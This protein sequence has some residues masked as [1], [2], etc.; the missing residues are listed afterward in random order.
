MV[1]KTG[2]RALVLLAPLVLVAALPVAGQESPLQWPVPPPGPPRQTAPSRLLIAA[3]DAAGELAA[4]AVPLDARGLG[5]AFAAGHLP[6]A[7][8]AWSAGDE[9][10]DLARVRSRLAGAGI[11]GAEAVVLYGE[12]SGSGDGGR[13]AVARL[14]WLLRWA[15]VRDVRLLAGGLV[16]WRAGGGA[17]ETG[18]PR[19]APAAAFHPAA[20]PGAAA[21]A[22]WISGTL[23]QAGVQLL[24]VRDA[25]GWERWATPPTFAAGHIPYSLPFDPAALLPA[26]GGWPDPAEV[27]RLA[28]R[29]PRPGDPVRPDSVFVLYGTDAGDPRPRLGYLLLSLAGLDARVYP[30]G[31]QEWRSGKERPVVRVITAQELAGRLRRDEPGL[32]GDRPSAGLILLDLRE[33][34]D[35][36]IGHLPGA[37]SLPFLHFSRDFETMVRMGWPAADRATAPLVLYCYGV[38]CVRSRK[39][40]ALAARLGFRDVIWFRGGIREWREAGYPLPETPPVSASPAPGSPASPA[41]G[42][43]AHA[44]GRPSP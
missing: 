27:R 34:R 28:T 14:F 22:G 11:S 37:R 13:E 8:P 26:A 42:S 32:A 40:G 10:A 3:S 16:A 20:T 39:A 4:G 36:A 38:D 5:P 6:G 31:W 18:A 12:P 9:D 29:G 35:F 21:D 15:G 17:L 43:P 1:L 24:D 44:G 30:G 7:V 23:V 33:P 25:R 2:Q 19:R 41:R